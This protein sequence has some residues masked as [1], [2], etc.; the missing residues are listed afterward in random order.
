MNG[1]R[2]AKFLPLPDLAKIEINSR[3]AIQS[4]K[5]KSMDH[6]SGLKPDRPEVLELSGNS[7]S[8]APV[9]ILGCPRSGTTLLYHMLLSA[10]RFAIYRA[11]SNF[12]NL[13]SPRFGGLRS[14]RSRETWLQSWANSELFRVSGLDYGAIRP[15]LMNECQTAGD[16]L[17]VFMEEVAAKQGVDRW[18]DCTPDHLLYVREIKREIP[19]ALIVHIIRD[20]R[21]VALSYAQ[22]RWANHLPW[23]RDQRLAVAALYWSWTVSEGR[24]HGSA[25]GKDYIE[26]R[27]EELVH[28]PRTPLSRVSE[29]IDQEL[30]YGR[31]QQVAIG[32]VRDPNTSFPGGSNGIF[33]PVGRWKTQITRSQL[34]GLEFLIG[35]RLQELGYEV[36]QASCSPNMR[37]R[38][39]RKLYPHVF[40]TKLWLRN[41]TP[42][43][44]F[45]DTGSMGITNGR[46]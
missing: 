27:F 3:R 31:I 34:S 45:T 41:H 28:D 1:D 35:D 30:D 18:A 32:S 12:F 36:S 20:G 23:D 38:A 21:D 15:K 6:Q 4:E 9:F 29:F 17:R 13:L 43:G 10:G 2:R 46:H 14:R 5:T 37:L 11:E 42:V 8:Q 16:C 33:N 44:R 7:R 26:V 40:A 25:L 19:D 24:K 39:M 22:Q